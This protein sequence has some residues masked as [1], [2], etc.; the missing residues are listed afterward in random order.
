MTPEILRDSTAMT[1]VNRTFALLRRYVR[2]RPSDRERCELCSV[3]LASEH[4][5]LIEQHSRRLLCACPACSLLFDGQGDT[6]YRRVPRNTFILR[7]FQ[8]TNAEWDDLKIPINMAFFFYSGPAAK[9]VAIYPSPAGPVESLLSLEMWQQIARDHKSLSNLK[10][11][12]EALLVNRLAGRRGFTDDDY[13]LAPID[14][15][16]KLVGLLRT[17]WRGLSGGNDLWDAV[18]EFFDHLRHVARPILEVPD[19]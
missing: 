15:C 12:V 6:K 7:D 13:F 5:H 9:M 10:P 14:Q 18:R 4:D 16:Y 1:E 19:A 17:H 8:I 11:D 2:Q 3:D